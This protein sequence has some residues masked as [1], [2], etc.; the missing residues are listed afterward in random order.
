MA[1]KF[2]DNLISRVFATERR[3]QSKR[4]SPGTMNFDRYLTNQE[5]NSYLDSLVENP[6]VRVNVIGKSFEGRDIRTVTITNGDSRQKIS[7]FI[8]AGIHGREWIAPATALYLITQLLDPKSSASVLLND[9]TFVILP[10]IN[11]DSYAYSHE[12]DRLWRKTRSFNSNNC[13]GTDGN[14]NFDYHWAEEGPSADP[15][16]D[17]YRGPH[18]FSES[19]TQ[20]LRDVVRDIAVTCKFY[21]S[22]HSF[23]DYILYPWAWTEEL[24]KTWQEIDGIAQIGAEAIKK[25]TGKKY[26]IGST[27]N[28]LSAA[29]G[30]S[31]DYMLAIMK[32]PIC[33]TMDLPGG[34]MSGFDPPAKMILD[35]VKESSSG[36]FAMAK[37]IVQKYNG[38]IY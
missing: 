23:G 17:I 34:G 19:E 15:C 1:L 2:T 13:R 37:A 24:P 5:I 8:D 31:D 12:V 26:V 27:T 11:P 3:V 25:A 7:I 35:S 18:A 33:M 32:I 21:L 10:L 28:V 29:P 16:S 22:L 20:A 6:Q 30:R 14:R 38:T 4:I 36:I 9:L